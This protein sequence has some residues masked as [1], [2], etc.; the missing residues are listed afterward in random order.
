MTTKTP[1]KSLPRP[2]DQRPRLTL[3][4]NREGNLTMELTPITTPPDWTADQ[5]FESFEDRWG[6]T[7]DY[8]R[9]ALNKVAE[10]YAELHAAGDAAVRYFERKDHRLTPVRPGTL[11]LADRLYRLSVITNTRTDNYQYKGRFAERIH[12]CR[13]AE[14]GRQR[15][16][17]A[18]YLGTEQVWLH[19]L[20][21]L[22]DALTWAAISL[23]D[24]MKSEHPNYSRS[25]LG[26]L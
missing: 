11:S 6:E 19:P 20:C 13:W 24:G 14:A 18:Y 10:G 12:A 22:A 16:M 1:P 26:E 4:R 17:T 23:E 2:Q 3:S 8:Y 15:I 5:D 21:D 7:E 25:D 9:D